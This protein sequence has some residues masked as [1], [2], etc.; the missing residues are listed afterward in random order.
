MYI[1]RADGENE[2]ALS[3]GEEHILIKVE[4]RAVLFI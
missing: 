2:N 3:L 1:Q 4:M